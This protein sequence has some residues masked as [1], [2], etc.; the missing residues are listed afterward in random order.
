MYF[1]NVQ[2]GLQWS[3]NSSMGQ[4]TTRHADT[5]THST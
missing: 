4:C 5:H 1:T 2:V 3:H